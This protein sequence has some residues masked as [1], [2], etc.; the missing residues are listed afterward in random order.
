MFC[1]NISF[2]FFKEGRMLLTVLRASLSCKKNSEG[3]AREDGG[4]GQQRVEGD[5]CIACSSASHLKHGRKK[6]K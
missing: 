5:H 1:F 3:P 4:G 2:F 6:D